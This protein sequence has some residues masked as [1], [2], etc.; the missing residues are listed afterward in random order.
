MAIV[1]YAE[2]LDDFK[3]KLKALQ[4]TP[5]P[6][7]ETER[8]AEFVA[9]AVAQLSPLQVGDVAELT[10]TPEIT[11]K[12]AWGWLGSKHML[13]AGKR[14]K[15][16]DVDWR[17]GA[18]CYLWEPFDQTW[19]HPHDRTEQPVDRPSGY[20]FSGRKLNKVADAAPVDR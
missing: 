15:V 6:I 12:I 8:V 2:S 1:R 3:M 4:N 7:W 14:G 19:I 11:D 5:F 18:W 20:Y 17:D 16:L 13:V 9:W 10:E